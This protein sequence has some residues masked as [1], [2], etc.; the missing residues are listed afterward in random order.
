MVGQNDIQKFSERI[1]LYGR[2][3]DGMSKDGN[4]PISESW[5]HHCGALSEGR[6]GANQIAQFGKTKKSMDRQG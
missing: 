6:A 1:G 5:T 4:E 3:K 2:L